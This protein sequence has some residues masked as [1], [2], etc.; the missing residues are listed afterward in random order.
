MFATATAPDY[1]D[2]IEHLPPG[3]SLFAENVSWEVYDRLMEALSDSNTVRV[4]YDQGRLEIMSPTRQH[5]KPTKVIA[6]LMA[7]ISYELD[8]DVESTGQTTLREQMKAKGAEPDDAYYV[9]NAEQILGTMDLDLAKDPPPDLV[10]ESD[11]TSS[12][13][14]RFVIY[15]G[16]GVPEIWQ[17]VNRTVSFWLLQDGAYQEAAESL[18]FPFLSASRLNAFMQIG[19]QHGQ[20]RASRAM[21]EWLRKQNLSA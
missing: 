11:V 14:N 7:A 5:E 9:Q 13:L 1:L 2:A 21:H 18:A 20:R 19:L 8:I 3:T 4:F 10:I 17:I 15:A 6:V 16:L 12:S